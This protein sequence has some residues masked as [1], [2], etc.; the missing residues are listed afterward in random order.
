MNACAAFAAGA[1][2]VGLV[3]LSYTRACT[4]T[5]EYTYSVGATRMQLNEDTGGFVYRR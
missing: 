5:G 2:Q 3:T 1:E 4:R